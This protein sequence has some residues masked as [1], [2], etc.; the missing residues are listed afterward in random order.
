[1]FVTQMQSITK[2]DNSVEIIFPL[3]CPPEEDQ[4]VQKSDDKLYRL[5]LI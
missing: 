5:L 4:F 2:Y 3:M 1:M